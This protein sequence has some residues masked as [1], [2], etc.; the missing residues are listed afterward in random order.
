MTLPYQTSSYV[1]WAPCYFTLLTLINYIFSLCFR[2]W[3]GL[4]GYKWNTL[5]AFQLSIAQKMITKPHKAFGF[6]AQAVEK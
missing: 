3:L 4:V 2:V 6:S 1:T 5:R